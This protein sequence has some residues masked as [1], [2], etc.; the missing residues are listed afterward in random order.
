MKVGLLAGDI[1]GVDGA[2]DVAL[3]PGMFIARREAE[4]ALSL[5]LSE[6]R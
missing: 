3:V 1:K 4:R 2:V 6:Y 5:I